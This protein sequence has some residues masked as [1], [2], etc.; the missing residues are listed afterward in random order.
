M[1]EIVLPPGVEPQASPNPA[2]TDWV[3]L[4]NM[5][6]VLPSSVPDRDDARIAAQ[7][8]LAEAFPLATN[9]SSIAAVAGSAYGMLVG[10]L[11]GDIVTSVVCNMVSAGSGMTLV[12]FGLYSRAGVRLAQ[13]ADVKASY[14]SGGANKFAHALSAPYTVPTTDGYYLAVI[15]VGG[16]P[17]TLVR[18]N[19]G[20][21]TAA[22]PG[23]VAPWGAQAAQSDLPTNL[24]LAGSVPAIWVA[25]A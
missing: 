21:A 5:G 20:F 2:T 9:V 23:G 13:T 11:A 4:W 22:A 6:Q 25:A 1:T 3:P 10:L 15:M 18:G 7:G 24:V 8:L 17:A 19:S 16:T 14:N 12:R